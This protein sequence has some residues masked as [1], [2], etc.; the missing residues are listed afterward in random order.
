VQEFF[1]I[2]R[3]EGTVP[4][5]VHFEM[6]GK[7]VTECTGGMRALTDEDLSSRY[8]TACDPR[9]NASQSLE[10][11]F[12]VAEELWCARMRPGQIGRGAFVKAGSILRLT[13]LRSPPALVRPAGRGNQAARRCPRKPL[14]AQ[15]AKR[16]AEAAA[17][18]GERQQYQPRGKMRRLIRG[19]S[20]CK[21]KRRAGV[22]NSR[23]S[24]GEARPFGWN[25][26]RMQ[27]H[28]TQFHPHQ[29]ANMLAGEPDSR[30]RRRGIGVGVGRS[31]D[32]ERVFQSIGEPMRVDLG[33][34]RCRAIAAAGLPMGGNGSERID[35]CRM[36]LPVLLPQHRS[37]PKPVEKSI[38]HHGYPL[39]NYRLNA[40]R[41]TGLARLG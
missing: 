22:E 19:R 4:G 30:Q 14:C 9:L 20:E 3:A 16:A 32:D 35:R 29:G 17:I 6:T 8:H 25:D 10:L 12:L 2:H 37:P 41:E 23:D 15:P 26:Q 13:F 34:G 36:T 27:R 28:A 24:L 31:L 18:V 33:P 5:G 38:P 11:A 21:V 1:A 7:D 40:A 39:V